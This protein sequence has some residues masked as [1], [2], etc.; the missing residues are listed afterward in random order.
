MP[1][2]NAHLNDLPLRFLFAKTNFLRCIGY[3]LKLHERPFKA[4]FI[5]NSSSYIT[6]ELSKLL[7]SCL[8]AIISCHKIL[9]QCMKLQIKNGVGQ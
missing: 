7:T 5:A 2:V 9:R 8:T 1:V 3:L 4:R 6:I